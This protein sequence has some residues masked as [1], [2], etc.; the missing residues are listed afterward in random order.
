[1]ANIFPNKQ[2]SL[3]NKIDSR[4]LDFVATSQKR[5]EVLTAIKADEVSV[6]SHVEH[7]EKS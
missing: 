1:M 2:A 4:N 7:T 6:T 5:F 3:Q